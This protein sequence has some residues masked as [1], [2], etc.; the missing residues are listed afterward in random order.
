MTHAYETFLP[1]LLPLAVGVG[2]AS[3]VLGNLVAGKRI[4]QATGR[5]LG[6][7]EDQDLVRKVDTPQSTLYSLLLE[8]PIT[9]YG[10]PVFLS[11]KL[12]PF[13]NLNASTKL[14]FIICFIISNLLLYINV[15]YVY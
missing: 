4:A 1:L 5:D 8:K 10:M 7:I 15:I 12:L 11:L 3:V 14:S 2:P 6:M 13:K 9:L